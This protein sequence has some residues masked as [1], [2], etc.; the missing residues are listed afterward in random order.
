MKTKI[1]KGRKKGLTKLVNTIKGLAP[2]FFSLAIASKGIDIC[3]G[4]IAKMFGEEIRIRLLEFKL[5]GVIEIE[6][7][8]KNKV[9]I[10]YHKLRGINNY[11]KNFLKRNPKWKSEKED[12]GG[13]ITGRIILTRVYRAYHKK[14]DYNEDNCCPECGRDYNDY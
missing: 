6:K 11:I 10:A 4:A 14:S 1:K 5:M 13:I 12:Y 2:L 9:I 7:R 8:D 3:T